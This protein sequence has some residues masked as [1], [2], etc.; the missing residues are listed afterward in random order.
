[1]L[2]VAA[3]ALFVFGPFLDE[4]GGLLGM[5]PRQTFATPAIVS[6]Q[7]FASIPIALLAALGLLEDSDGALKLTP[8]G[9]MLGNEVF[10]RFL[11]AE[12]V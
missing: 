3:A 1:M 6:T 5:R 7:L 4:R 8:R 2:L 9:R 12:P 11:A 10:S